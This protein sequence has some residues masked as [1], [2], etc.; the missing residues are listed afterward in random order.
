[1]SCWPPSVRWV[2]LHGRL[3]VCCGDWQGLA[4]VWWQAGV[5]CC[6]HWK[7]GRRDCCVAPASTSTGRG[8]PRRGSLS[9]TTGLSYKIWWRS[10]PAAP[11]KEPKAPCAGCART[12]KKPV[13]SSEKC[14]V[15]TEQLTLVNE[16]VG[17]FDGDELIDKYNS[18]ESAPHS[19]PT[20]TAATHPWPKPW[21]PSPNR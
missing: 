11:P 12:F 20:P 9:A 21:P 4:N 10:T 18:D 13:N 3:A 17:H 1:M 15:K 7:P 14:C 16:A 5:A 8:A 19:T 2:V 6:L